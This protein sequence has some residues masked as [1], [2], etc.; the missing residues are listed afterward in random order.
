M[1]SS[2]VLY[3]I[4]LNQAF[5]ASSEAFFNQLIGQSKACIFKESG[6]ATSNNLALPHTNQDRVSAYV[7][8]TS[9]DELR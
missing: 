5:L 7:L 3:L 9:G 2:C 1:K 6:I 8:A 4:P